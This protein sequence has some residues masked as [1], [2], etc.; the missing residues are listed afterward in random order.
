MPARLLRAVGDRPQR[1][2]RPAAVTAHICQ[3]PTG[4]MAAEYRVP[5]NFVA[6]TGNGP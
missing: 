4:V 6:V 2:V 1:R 3:S 5:A